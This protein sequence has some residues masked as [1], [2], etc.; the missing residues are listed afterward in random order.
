MQSLP[1]PLPTFRSMP[2]SRSAGIASARVRQSSALFDRARA[3]SAEQAPGQ[4]RRLR[5]AVSTAAYTPRPDSSTTNWFVL[6]G[7]A[8][9]MPPR[10][11]GAA[12]GSFGRRSA[13]PTNLRKPHTSLP[14]RRR[15]DHRRA[16]GS[17]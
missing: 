10:G 1:L 2:F 14:D 17:S 12:T 7:L 16:A 13:C 15:G 4:K 11:H 8:A 5:R 6:V 3:F 9:D